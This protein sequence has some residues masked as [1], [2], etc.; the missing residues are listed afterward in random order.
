MNKIKNKIRRLLKQLVLWVFKEEI[1]SIGLDTHINSPSWCV[2][3]IK[4]EKEDKV[5][6]I[7]L[8]PNL[9]IK[10]IRSLI[11]IIKE[12]SYINVDCNPNF[13]KYFI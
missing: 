5:T 8:S 13:K 9:T 4:G 6:F 3:N 12:F 11:S 10:E 7:Q 1:I 2:I